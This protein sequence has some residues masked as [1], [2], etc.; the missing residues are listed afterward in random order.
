MMSKSG[1]G[2]DEGKY[3]ITV[4]ENSIWDEYVK[5]DPTAKSMRF[6]FFPY[7]SVWHEI[8]RK[9]R[10]TGER[11][12]DEK[13]TADA[14]REEEAMETRDYYVPTADWNPEE[15]FVS[16]DGDQTRA[17]MNIDP[18]THSSSA[19]KPNSDKIKK[20]KKPQAA[21]EDRLV[22]MVS[23]FCQDANARLGTLTKVLQTEFGDLEKC[24]EVENAV[25][26][27]EGIDENEQLVIVQR[28]HNKP[29]DM[30]LFFSM[31]LHKRARLVR[32]MLNGRF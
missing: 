30:H 27:I 28:L 11:A 12:K 29:K 10:A 8:F 6:K 9:D 25:A 2:W 24:A 4:E 20:R 3:M 7:F 15:G 13:A 32:L 23:S 31:P 17:E 1:F 14:I 16:N 18:T 21:P 5:V 19:P 26:E 22:D